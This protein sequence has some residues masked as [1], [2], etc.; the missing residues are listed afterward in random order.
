MNQAKRIISSRGKGSGIRKFKKKRLNDFNNANANN[1]NNANNNLTKCRFLLSTQDCIHTESVTILANK[2]SN[3]VNDITDVHTPTSS[4]SH[5]LPSEPSAEQSDSSTKKKRWTKKLKRQRHRTP[6]ITT[7]SKINFPNNQNSDSIDILSCFR[8]SPEEALA[9]EDQSIQTNIYVKPLLVLD[10]NGILCHRIRDDDIPSLLLSQLSE[11]DKND[12][13]TTLPTSF[14]KSSS[15]PETEKV[16]IKRISRSIYRSWIGHIANTPIVA[17][18]DLS[19]FLTFLDEH[20]TL[21]I[22]SSAKKKTVNNL[23]KLLFPDNIASRLLFVWG[24]NR[25]D[26]IDASKK[27][28]TQKSDPTNSPT[29]KMDSKTIDD[30]FEGI[31]TEKNAMGNVHRKSHYRDTIFVKRLTKVWAQYP[32]WNEHNTILIDDS[33]DKCPEKYQNNT[34]HPPP[35]LGIDMS[36]L[37]KVRNIFM[38]KQMVNSHDE[39]DTLYS[40]SINEK[41]QRMFFDELV[42]IWKIKKLDDVLPDGQEKEMKHHEDFIISSHPSPQDTLFDFLSKHGKGHMNWRG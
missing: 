2:H 24:Q 35:I 37:V 21:S 17:R 22:W 5:S 20:F 25:C 32:L 41:K 38:E 33:P 4:H 26:S 10:I 9:N 42:N 40:D 13:C 15:T 39:F 19:N 11:L 14:G 29:D 6:I 36:T 8:L 27:T 1:N 28:P 30:G 23:V 16:K 34:I 18:T 7:T 31:D 3:H 12:Q